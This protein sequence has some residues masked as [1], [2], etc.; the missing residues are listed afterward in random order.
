MPLREFHNFIGNQWVEGVRTFD[1]RNPADNSL[2]GPVHEAGQA[3]V[4]A[5]VKAARA[6]LSGPWG[7]LSV[8]QRVAL[9]HK[10]AEGIERRAEEFI[11]AEIAD[12]GKPYGLASHLDIPRGAANFKVFADLI[13]NVPTESFTMDT[14]D[15]GKAV[16]YAV[17][18]PRGVIAVV[19]P[20]N[21]PL[22]LMTWKVG[23]ALA[24]GNTVVV[25]PSEETPATA[26]LLGEVMRDAGVPAGVYNVVHGFGENSAGAFLTAHPEV[27]G[28][29][30]TGETGTGEIIMKAAAK[31]LRPVSLELGGKNAGVVFADAD[32]DKAVAGIARSAF[33][34]SG[35]V[36]LGTERVYVQRPL[37]ERFVQAL[38]AKV[39][40]LRIGAPHGEGTTMGPLV[41]LGHREKVLGYYRQAV[42]DGA[43]VISGGGIPPMPAELA[44]GAWIQPTIWT[45]LAET[46]A[47]I[48]EEIFGP[49]CHIAPFD[50]EDEVVQLVNATRYGLAA[51][52]WTSNLQVAHRMGAA[53]DVGICWINSWFLRDLRTAFGG[54]KQS[55][56]GREGG[57]H[58]LEFYTELRNICVRL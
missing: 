58:S 43:T 54:A 37:F 48:R 38:K 51:S 1:N 27:N 24:C 18:A 42:Q 40:T 23:P 5:A 41:S 26:T 52:V 57:V 3:Q 34:N 30:F 46:S 14:P 20:W 10:V 35:Q 44:E 33:E 21:L 6:A 7:Q 11:A 50:D 4:D 47:V 32:L 36:C 29:T 39:E 19:C 56:I 16:N 2:I 49:C 28:I 22:L 9:L 25:K 31:G 17:R 13:K 12:T 15:G 45:G 8:A 55:G 53:L